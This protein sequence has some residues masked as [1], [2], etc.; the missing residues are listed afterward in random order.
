MHFSIVTQGMR[1]AAMRK[2]GPVRFRHHVIDDGKRDRHGD[3]VALQVGQQHF[4][5]S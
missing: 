3:R 5:S 2:S 4:R 1:R